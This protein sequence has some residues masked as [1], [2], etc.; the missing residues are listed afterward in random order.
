M[1][2][3]CPPNSAARPTRLAAW[4]ALLTVLLGSMV[5]LGWAYDI[6]V[7]K[8]VLPGW[9]SMK[10]NAAAC[11]IMTGVALCLL[12][13]PPGAFN[14][15]QAIFFSRLARLFIV[16]V[17]LIAALTLGEYVFGWNPGIDH[18]LANEAFGAV[19]TTHPGRMAPE[20]ALNFILLAVALWING[21]ARKT[22]YSIL[23]A[24][25]IGLL[26]ITL[27]LA[28]LI[29]YAMSGFGAN[30]WF[31]LTLMAVNAAILFIMLGVAVIAISWQPDVLSW[32]LSI[33]TTAVFACGM[34]VLVFIGLSSSRSQFWM[35][36]KSRQISHDETMLRDIADLMIEVTDAQTHLRSYIITGDERFKIHYDE[37]KNN[38]LAELDALR[39]LVAAIPHQRQQLDWIEPQVNAQLQ[40]MQ[41]MAQ[42]SRSGMSNA[43]RNEMIA[44]GE[45]L[46]DDLHDAFD[47]I[48]VEH[49]Q[50][51]GQLKRELEQVSLFVYLTIS[52]GTFVSLLIFLTVIFR[53]NFA[54]SEREQRERAMRESEEKFRVLY[55]SSTDAIMLLNGDGF[56]DCNRAALRMFGCSTRDDFMRKHPSQFS[57]PT[58][59][60]GEDSTSLANEHIAAAFKNGSKLFEWV[61]SRLDGGEFAAEVLL[62][63]LELGGRPML[64]ATVRDITKRKQHEQ[65]IAALLELSSSTEKIDERTLLQR[66]LDTVQGLTG[67]RVGFLHFVSADQ[68]NIELLIWSNGTVV[69]YCQAA[70]DKHY[71]LSAAGVWADSIR[72]KQVLMVNDCATLSDNKGLPEGYADLRR[73]LSV[74]ILEDDLVRM[75]VGV[76]NAATDYDEYDV[77]TVKLFSYDLYRIV[78]NKRTENSL[79]QLS[80][81]VEQSTS[82]IVI[83][84]LEAKIEYANAAFYNTTG[85]SVA[86]AIGQNPRLLQSGKTSPKVYAEMW[87]SLT[88]GKVWAGELYNRRK[89]G[90]EYVEAAVIS[91]V[92]QPDGSVS[93]Y[94]A[95]K[96]DITQLKQ[97]Q[98]SLRQLNA[99][100]EEKVLARTA[101]LERARLEAERASHAKSEFL[102]TMSHEI[103]TPMNGVIGMIDVLLQSSLNEPQTEMANII[104]DSAFA[105][106]TLID[107][108]LDFSKIEAGKFQVD[109]V[110]MNVASTVEGVCETLARVAEKKGVELTL[111]TDPA[112]PAGVLGDPARLRQTLI[113]LV[114]NAIKFS[115]GQGRLGR[116]SVRA[117]L[118]KSGLVESKPD[119]RGHFPRSSPPPA[120]EGRN[121][122]LHDVEQILLEFCVLDNGVGINKEAQKRLFSA[123][124]QADSS[125]TRNFGGTGLGL[126]ISKQLVKLMG[127][128]IT[129]QS[130]PGKGALFCARIPFMPLADADWGAAT[131]AGQGVSRLDA[132]GG[133]VG[134][135]EEGKNFSGVNLDLQSPDLVAGLSCLVLGEAGSL[136]DDLA[137][138]LRYGGAKVEHAPDSA[139]A[140][141]A[142]AGHLRGLCVVVIDTAGRSPPL[143]ELHA[144]ARSQPGLD[145]R[146]VV[147][148]RGRRRRARIEAH[149]LV[150]LDADGMP[151]LRFL[152]AVAVAAGRID[153][154]G[155]RNQADEV[156]ETMGPLSR[157]HARRQG[158]LILVAEDNEINQKVIQ[159]QLALLGDV[160]DI[161]G[162]GREAL[163]LWQGGAY[164]ILL[165]D[166]HMPEMDGYE[167]TAAIRAAEADTARIPIIAFT[168]NALRGEAAHC[169]AAG[170]D[171]Y[172]SKPVQLANLK[173]ML[174]K[175]LP[176]ASAEAIENG[177]ERAAPAA[178]TPAAGRELALPAA[179][180]G[181]ADIPASAAVAVDVN[182]L[183]A[184]V[185]DDEATIGELLHDFRLSAENIASE[186]RAAC[187]TGQA[188]AA[189][190]WAHKLKSS[191]RSVGAL[192]LG[193]LCAGMEQ[194]GKAGDTAA[195]AA[196]LPDFERELVRVESFLEGR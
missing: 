35:E 91:P 190:A 147:I 19:G 61:H 165:T 150:V 90:G 126:V 12:A 194:A 32:S 14:P 174:D 75:I 25:S 36:E 70:S 53:L 74:P 152:E 114:G 155:L 5:L 183:K 120:G 10:A 49:R 34:A 2:L 26:V 129:L 33:R 24:V 54:E 45:V 92:R 139:V 124:T 44:Q 4:I 137:I 179:G 193:E 87:A 47:A 23:A 3:A 130:E 73:L 122:S 107:D 13:R 59:P 88:S 60:G 178:A 9:V 116:V 51:I 132:Q 27:A 72:L 128:D 127:G 21:G 8:S 55:E 135:V 66:G 29:T 177:T 112:I 180:S 196:L 181:Q 117:L 187:A 121:E 148:G 115:S 142:I 123:F 99:E 65:R 79:R 48:D 173:A 108:I 97:A 28:A 189:G 158:R 86:E 149:N 57:P 144:A 84:N 146:F 96:T 176:T 17:G 101:E 85:Y 172:V 102:A 103:R 41:Q 81:A 171:D 64:Q 22:R 138:Y 100:L 7:L 40:W 15:R 111:F 164:G 6:P 42:T 82:S 119:G 153:E 50:F 56:F 43:A 105:L 83:T 160:A 30:G 192:A 38:S 94:L 175:W 98:E 143:D 104:H 20:T 140:Q 68:N 167:L 16:P 169:L 67:S 18:W 113:N 11:F 31:G 63:A 166:L 157:E 80:L 46:L 162:N 109:R 62:T 76:G 110:P 188:V 182:V 168:A 156:K 154:Y 185:G 78:Q 161:A 106:L 39:K 93:H 89:D 58:Q 184:L 118:V 170:M 71:P 125:T 131:G 133:H 52:I 159:Q 163:K 1:P 191:A 145:A 186:L 151:R 195:L 77:E 141:Q 136:A 37:A 69:H 95:V 134:S